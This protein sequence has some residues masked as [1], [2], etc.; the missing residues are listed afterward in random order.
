[1]SGV[2]GEVILTTS[3]ISDR[4]VCLRQDTKLNNPSCQEAAE[5]RQSMIAQLE[6]LR[7]P[8]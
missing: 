6:L 5:G 4:S 3:R 2:S 1:M 7:V 8:R